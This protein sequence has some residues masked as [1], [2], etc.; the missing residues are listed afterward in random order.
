MSPDIANR[1]WEAKLTL[2]E[3]HWCNLRLSMEVALSSRFSD[4]L[5]LFY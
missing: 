4:I 3:N 2:I 5:S 1:S